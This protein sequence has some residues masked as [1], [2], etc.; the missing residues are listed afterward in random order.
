MYTTVR[1]IL[2]VLLEDFLLEL[3][4]VKLVPKCILVATIVAE[5][6]L[7]P[8]TFKLAANQQHLSILG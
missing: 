1:C 3:L 7:G 5:V 4:H 2:I 6:F 8:M